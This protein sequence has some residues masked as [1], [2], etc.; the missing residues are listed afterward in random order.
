MGGKDTLALLS[1]MMGIAWIVGGCTS[2][3][4]GAA[5]LVSA[6]GGGGSCGAA[7][8]SGSGLVLVLARVGETNRRLHLAQTIL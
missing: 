6:A 2:T 5:G 4:A 8:G 3:G 7:R 1:G